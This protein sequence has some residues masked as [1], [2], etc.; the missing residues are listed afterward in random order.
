MLVGV[1][2]IGSCLRFCFL[3]VACLLFVVYVEGERSIPDASQR[4]RVDDGPTL[5]SA[6]ALLRAETRWLSSA[7]LAR[8]GGHWLL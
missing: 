2:V 1:P 5:L 3:F 7:V 4:G 8:L 6:P